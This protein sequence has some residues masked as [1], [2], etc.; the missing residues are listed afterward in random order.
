MGAFT[1]VAGD[2]A[3]LFGVIDQHA[4]LAGISAIPIA[5][6][7]FSLGIY[8]TVKGFKENPLILAE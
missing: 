5:L 8:L 3:V 6:W 1:L 2:V 7:E 4:P